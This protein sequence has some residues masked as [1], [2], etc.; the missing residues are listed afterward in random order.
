M[1]RP[2]SDA[3]GGLIRLSRATPSYK[4]NRSALHDADIPHRVT[5][6]NFGND[7]SERIARPFALA[8]KIE[9][10]RPLAAARRSRDVR[11]SF[12]RPQ[13]T[14][15][16]GKA[17]AEQL[18][19]LPIRCSDGFPPLKFILPYGSVHRKAPTT[20]HKNG[21]IDELVRDRADTDARR[22][23]CVDTAARAA[24]IAGLRRVE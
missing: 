2:P 11:R 23:R 17:G 8:S 9:F 4:A 20:L 22:R 15:D 13:R 5:L 19:V 7:C 16:I 18:F 6:E 12:G 21:D 1:L 3:T 14:R 24:A 10:G